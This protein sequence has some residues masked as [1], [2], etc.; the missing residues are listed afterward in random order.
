VTLAI[1][2]LP[3]VVEALGTVQK[4]QGTV[5]P[6]LHIV[7]AIIYYIAMHL[8]ETHDLPWVAWLLTLPPMIV[9]YLVGPIIP[10]LADTLRAHDGVEPING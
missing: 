1:Y 3:V 10:Y 4:P 9:G 6:T 8:L 7:H 2:V 5:S